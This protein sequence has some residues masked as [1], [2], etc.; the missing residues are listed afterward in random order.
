MTI[1]VATPSVGPT[2]SRPS[3]AVP[4]SSATASSIVTSTPS[5]SSTSQLRTT[6]AP[7]A[8][9]TRAM[10]RLRIP[11]PRITAS[12]SQKPSRRPRESLVMAPTITAPAAMKTSGSH[13]GRS[14]GPTSVNEQTAAS[15]ISMTMI[16]ISAVISVETLGQSFGAERR[17]AAIRTP[18]P[19]WLLKRLPR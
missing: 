10:M 12:P 13:H 4:M 15:A 9:I 19:M 14:S 3:T 5:P 11:S 7:V 16:G 18:M 6:W 2:G 1:A 17:R 8:N